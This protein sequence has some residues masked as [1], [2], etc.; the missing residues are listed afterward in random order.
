MY[1]NNNYVQMIMAL[2]DLEEKWGIGVIDMFFDLEMCSLPTAD[3]NRYMSDT[4]HPNALG[5]EK[6]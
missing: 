2:Y 5:Y 3:Y 4:I 1:N 6:W